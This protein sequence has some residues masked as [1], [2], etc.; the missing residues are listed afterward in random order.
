MKK[1]YS[2]FLVSI[3][4]CL[5]V[6][7]V[8]AQSTFADVHYLLQ[9]NC[10][11]SGCHDGSGSPSFNVMLS[12]SAL[13]AQ[14]VNTTPL[15]PTS[16][17]K[18]NKL[19][20][21]GHV[22]RSFLLRKLAHGIA[23]VS[24]RLALTTGEGNIMPDVYP[25]HL[26]PQEVELVRQWILF[27]A[28]KTGVVV[29]TGLINKYYREGGIDDTYPVHPVPAAG[30]GFQIYVGKIFITPHS[31]TY[32]YIKHKPEY[33]GNVEVPRLE[34]MLPQSGHHM[35]IYTFLPGGE[36]NYREG[37]RPEAETSHADVL[38]GIGLTKGYNELNL[39]P[40]TAY[41]WPANG[42]LDLNLHI[43]NT[44]DS[45]LATDLYFNIYTQTVGTAQHN[46]LIRNFPVF[47]IS[48]P[49]DGQEHTFTEIAN[50]T[51]ETRYWKIWQMYSHTHKYGTDYDIFMRN[52][53]GSMG[54]QEYEGWL[55]YEQGGINL[56]YYRFGVDVTF[57]YYP[58]DSLLV[59]DPR[60][61]LIHRAKWKNTAGPDPIIWGLT[62]DEEMMVM[63]F[64]Y[65]QGDLLGPLG[66]DD[67]EN[68]ILP[69]N[70]FPNPVR[71]ALGLNYVLQKSS[72][73]KVELTNILGQTTLLL[74]Q[75]NKPAGNYMEEV[76]LDHRFAPGIY[77]L[78]LYANKEATTRRIVIE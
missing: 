29:D 37:L 23:N 73:I 15:N 19:V 6:S 38:D 10:A 33:T 72:D 25:N 52:P 51:T 8:S 69:L 74:S 56:G 63:G 40:N 68:K 36:G 58:D 13:Y 21:P 61:G 46:M 49:Q 43:K 12:D 5:F 7:E 17:G 41:F 45:V 53:D 14:L 77:L 60:L 64:Q 20:M 27:G 54:N 62:S 42:M 57:K 75:N 48:I 31:E 16:A 35:V 4:L 78:T 55:S 18:G 28:P 3:T 66:T 26:A 76:E 44:S 67:L 34:A 65:I 2:S 22:E 39:P 9:T 71:D 47:T 1:L 59:V 32:Y 50:D 30:T 24:N 70:V 11:G